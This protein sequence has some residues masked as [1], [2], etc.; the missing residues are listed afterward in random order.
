[1]HQFRSGVKVETGILRVNENSGN[2]EPLRPG[3]CGDLP[4]VIGRSCSCKDIHLRRARKSDGGVAEYL[5]RISSPDV[6]L[7]TG[8][9]GLAVA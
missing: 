5:H 9:K 4:N 3:P 1:M 6:P 8:E 7:S 2:A